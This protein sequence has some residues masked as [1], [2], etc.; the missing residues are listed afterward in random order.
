MAPSLKATP[1]VSIIGA[2]RL[3]SALALALDSA[4]YRIDAVA[5]RRLA[6]AVQASRKLVPRPLPLAAEQLGRLPSSEIIIIST[7]DDQIPVVAANLARATRANGKSQVYL[8]TSGAL[9]SSAL[10]ALVDK[11]HHVGSLH[12]LIAVSDRKAGAKSLRAAYWCVEG[13]P[14]GTRAA[15]EIVKRLGGH[16]F[17]IKSNKKPLYHA[18]AVMVAGHTVALFDVAVAML[19]KSGVSRKRAREI[20]LPL[21]KSNV[22]N[23]AKHGPERALTGSFVRGDAA[24]IERHLGALKTSDE[25]DALAVYRILGKRSLQLAVQA[26]QLD[27]GEMTKIMKLLRVAE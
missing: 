15:R 10:K 7:P 17:S 11:G 5:A 24:T 23:L 22:R 3:G 2:G 9:S 1:S 19:I 14:A 16:S 8:H 12:P 26:K 25:E 20:L 13:D 27:K 6:N 4:G 18:A 21:I